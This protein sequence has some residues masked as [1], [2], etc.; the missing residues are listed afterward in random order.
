MNSLKDLNT[1]Y[2]CDTCDK[3][4]KGRV[5]LQAHQYQEHHENPNIDQVGDVGDK[6]I[7]RVCLKLFTRK[8]DVKAHILRVHMGERRYP[9]T[10]CG[11]RFK[12]S[13]HLR[14]HLRTHTGKFLTILINSFTC[15]FE[16]KE[17]M[18]KLLTYMDYVRHGEIQNRSL[19]FFRAHC[20]C[21]L[22][23]LI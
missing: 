12:E 16:A 23:C 11:K 4:I 13:T 22:P 6:H 19:V 7:C 21:I 17:N 1:P 20:P 3:T 5:N 9:C 18:F 15:D 10:K 8:S 2:Q 14:K